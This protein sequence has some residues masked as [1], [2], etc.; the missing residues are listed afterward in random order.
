MSEANNPDALDE[1]IASVIN[2]LL[3]VNDPRLIVKALLGNAAALAQL[4][5]AAKRGTA[6]QVASAFS[7]ALIDALE[8]Q[9][10]PEEKRIVVA[11]ADA[12]Q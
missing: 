3:Q 7:A 8:P 12:L 1:Q 4:I 9:E 2:T 5:I 11:S 6:A 10:Q